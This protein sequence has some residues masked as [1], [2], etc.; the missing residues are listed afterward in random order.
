MLFDKKISILVP[1]K[2]DRSYRDANW[3]WLKK[4]YELLLPNA[5]LCIG[6]YDGE[7]FSRSAAINNA[8]RLATRD[9]FIITDADIVFDVDQIAR[10]I[11]GL[12]GF[13]WI[14]PYTILNYLTLKQTNELQKMEPNVTLKAL[15]FTGC[16]QRDCTSIMFGGISVV[17]RNYFEKIGG[18]DERFKDWGYED[19]AFQESLDAI[20]G[21]HKRIRT[22][23]WH[24]YHPPVSENK[25]YTNMNLYNKFYNNKASIISNFN[26][27]TANIKR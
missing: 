4:R 14:I 6:N 23:L 19:N 13:T 17:P 7:P 22:S 24:M 5:E 2:S 18:F 25:Y 21:H 3:H 10:A 20:C 15:D 27:R 26:K 1:Y 16:N 11:L 9:I 12:T 8:A